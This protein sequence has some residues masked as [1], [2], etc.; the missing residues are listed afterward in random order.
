M[1]FYIEYLDSRGKTGP[2]NFY[3]TFKKVKYVFNEIHSGYIA[4]MEYWAYQP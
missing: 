4:L 1:F 2:F 3:E